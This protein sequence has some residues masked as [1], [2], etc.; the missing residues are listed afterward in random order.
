MK[1]I[2]KLRADQVLKVG[3][4]RKNTR[5]VKRPE[6]HPLRDFF[7]KRGITQAALARHLDIN[8]ATLSGY[9]NGTVLITVEDDEKL[10]NVAAIISAEEG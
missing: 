3:R 1:L 6:P 2:E 8:P 4:P 10:R 7:A 9:M 5:Y